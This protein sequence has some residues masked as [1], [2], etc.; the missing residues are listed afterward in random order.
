MT[1]ERIY[2]IL[3]KL[4]PREFQDQYGEEMTR[5]FQENLASEG[6]S[7]KLWIQTFADAFSSASREHVQGGRMSLLNKLAGISSVLI[8]VW[9]VVFLSQVLRNDLPTVASGIEVTFHTLLFVLVFAGL[10]ARP[11]EQRN[12]VWWLTIVSLFAILPAILTATFGPKVPVL[13]WVLHN[14]QYLMVA[15]MTCTCLNFVRLKN[16][17]F[18]FMPEFWGLVVLLLS[19]VIQRFW[20]GPIILDRPMIGR[21]DLILGSAAFISGWVLLGFALWSRASNPQP[22]ALT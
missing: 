14:S 20:I 22:Q 9:Q 11:I 8:G 6:S 13:E 21:W 17:Q 10:L 18:V 2:R 12:Q 4:Y 7:F 5:V 16:R 19:E 15:L 3:L 1:P